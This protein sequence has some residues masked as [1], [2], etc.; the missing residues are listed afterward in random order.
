M[1]HLVRIIS[2]GALLGTI[3][4]ALAFFNRSIDLETAKTAM[5]AAT[6]VWFIATPLWMGRQPQARAGRNGDS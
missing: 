6:V 3:G 1:S 2:L 4:P 5:L